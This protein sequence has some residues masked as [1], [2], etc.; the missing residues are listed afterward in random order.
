[1]RMQVQSL[2]SL[3]GLRIC[4]AMSCGVG[5][6]HSSDPTLLWLWYRPAATAPIQPLAWESPYATGVSLKRPEK[7][8]FL[9]I[10][11]SSTVHFPRFITVL[12][13]F[14][15]WCFSRKRRNK[16]NM[17]CELFILAKKGRSLCLQS[18]QH[19]ER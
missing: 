15:S 2:S 7:M 11:L 19:P 17:S 13:I 14:C 16:T 12:T 4:I 9:L 10:K 3:S 1:M 18:N 5:L 6:R 8:N